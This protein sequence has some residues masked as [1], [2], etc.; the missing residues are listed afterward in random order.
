MADWDNIDWDEKVEAIIRSK[1]QVKQVNQAETLTAP[2]AFNHSESDGNYFEINEQKKKLNESALKAKTSNKLGKKNEAFVQPYSGKD[3][4][5]IRAFTNNS[6]E[7]HNLIYETFGQFEKFIFTHQCD[8]THDAIVELLKI[9]VGLLEVPFHAHHK[10]LLEEISK[11]GS[12]WSQL[13]EFIKEFLNHKHKDVK[14]LLSVDMNG[15]FENLEYLVHN[16]LVNNSFNHSM[17]LILDEIVEVL[18]T[19][20]GSKWSQPNRLEILQVEY[21]NN[22]NVHRIYDVSDM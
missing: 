22:L 4:A 3:L 13:I 12:F 8:L 20:N 19:F 7:F 10:M 1:E 2:A 21:E 6:T 17:E 5:R 15:F 18:K 9:D 14:F 16:M 11:L